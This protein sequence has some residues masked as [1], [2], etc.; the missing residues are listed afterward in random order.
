KL[1]DPL[2]FNGKRDQLESWLTSLQIVIWGKEQDYTTDKSKIMIALS[3][4]AK[5]QVDK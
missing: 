3:H 4:M 2:I 1:A 5:D